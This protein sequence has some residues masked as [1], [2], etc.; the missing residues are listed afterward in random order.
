LGNI[1]LGSTSAP[2][3]D[4]QEDANAGVDVND[5]GV[6]RDMNDVWQNN[7]SVDILFDLTA[8]SGNVDIG[9]W[10]DWGNDDA[11]N[12]GTDYFSFA[13]VPGGSVQTRSITVPGSGVYTVGNPVFAR[14]RIFATGDAPG[15]SL[16][17]GDYI[18]LSSNGEVEDY[19]WLFEPTAVTL[20]QANAS[21]DISVFLWIIA[22]T[23]T[24]LAITTGIFFVKRELN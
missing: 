9:M 5:D 8:V 4:G 1:Y 12:P 11:F 20:V 21:R 15:G 23:V 14:V 18:G 10:I 13:G 22:L 7:T 2:K 24:F 16:D 19:R 6:S 3:T 17:S